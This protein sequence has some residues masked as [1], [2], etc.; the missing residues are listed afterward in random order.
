MTV[1]PDQTAH[2][3]ICPYCDKE[4]FC[5]EEWCKEDILFRICED[6]VENDI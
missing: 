1:I 3:H 6:C 4:Y 5:T 2:R